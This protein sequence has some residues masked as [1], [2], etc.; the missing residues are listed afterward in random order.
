[1]YKRQLVDELGAGLQ[2]LGLEHVLDEVGH[3]VLF[4]DGAAAHE[5]VAGDLGVHRGVGAHGD[6]SLIHI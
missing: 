5:V 1:M 4:E 2:G 3:G 6:L